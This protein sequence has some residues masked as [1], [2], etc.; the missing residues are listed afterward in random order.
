[1]TTTA[2]WAATG[3]IH[4]VTTTADSG[5]GSLRNAIQ[6][7]NLTPGADLIRFDATLSGQVIYPLTPLTALV[8]GATTIDGDTNDDGKPDI[9]LCGTQQPRAMASRSAATPTAWA[10]P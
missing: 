4:T 10:A 5:A 7:A 6:A 3:T 8:D 9:A 1:L 2:A